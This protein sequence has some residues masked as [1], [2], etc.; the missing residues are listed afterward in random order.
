MRPLVYGYI[1]LS[2]ADPQ[3]IGDCLM[4]D[5]AAY[6]D[7]EG[8]TLAGV[9]TDRDEGGNDQLGRSGFV[10][11][12]ESL[13]RPGVSGVLIPSLTHFSRFPGVHQA[14]RALIELETGARVFVMNQPS[15]ERHDAPGRTTNAAG[16]DPYPT[17]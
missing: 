8:L 7:R 2:P 15:E 5:L 10:V 4:R 6:A 17:S 9:F 1:R 3:D 12:V 16:N 11:M 13:R 14:M